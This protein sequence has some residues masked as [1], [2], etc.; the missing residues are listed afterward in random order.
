MVLAA[1]Q[2]VLARLLVVASVA[3]AV[4][5]GNEPTPS[6]TVAAGDSIESSV[7]AEIYAGALARTGAR[8][9]IASGLGS[10]ADYLAAL[11]AG[12]VQVVGEHTGA[13]L[14]HLDEHAT[15]R[16]PEKV[17]E[18][19][20]AALPEG[21][22]VSDRAEGADLRPRVLLTAQAA[23]QDKVRRVGDLAPRCGGLT[24]GVATMPGLLPSAGRERV[25]GCDFAATVA[26]PDP[27]ALR[28]ALLDGRVHVGL[29]GGP[30]ELTPGA[31][32]GLAVL[33]DDAYA[34]RAENVLPLFRKGL[35]DQ[36]Q[37]KKLNYVAGELMTDELAAMIRSVRDDGAAPGDVARA[38]LDQHSL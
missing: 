19:V 12:R 24:A 20:S 14:A 13:L 29:L 5:C 25:D 2:R 21:L 7:L 10:R 9:A 18:A 34:V 1:S 15:V 28:K 8:T 35:L 4:S 37:I 26:F 36:R 16:L 27:A 31:T 38:W 6:I 30:P 33:A 23:A 3:L 22:V 32:D 11:D 17:A